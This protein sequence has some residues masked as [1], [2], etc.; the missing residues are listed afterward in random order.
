MRDNWQASDII[1]MA[2]NQRGGAESGE[3]RKRVEEVHV[4]GWHIVYYRSVYHMG[5]ANTQP[6]E[7][8]RASVCMSAQ[9][10]RERGES[11]NTLV[12]T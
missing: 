8:V 6:G 7:H 5:I 11:M 10:A 9:S 12:V 3:E 2:K 4:N 1:K